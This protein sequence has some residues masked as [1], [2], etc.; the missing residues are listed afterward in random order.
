MSKMEMFQLLYRIFSMFCICNSVSYYGFRT[1]VTN[2]NKV[3]TITLYNNFTLA[4]SFIQLALSLLNL[5]F[6]Y[7]IHKSILSP[8]LLTWQI[9]LYYFS[10]YIR[11][12]KLVPSN[13]QQGFYLNVIHFSN[14][15]KWKWLFTQTIFRKFFLRK[16]SHVLDSCIYNNLWFFA[17]NNVMKYKKLIFTWNLKFKKVTKPCSAV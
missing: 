4:D 12:V 1:L 14:L 11:N 16:K 2:Y 6:I 7:L 9:H 5:M 10:P 15:S 17:I 3:N 8:G 13:A